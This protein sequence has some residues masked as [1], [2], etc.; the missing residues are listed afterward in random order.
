MA[1]ILVKQ[2]RARGKD[3][4][5]PTRA[6]PAA[7]EADEAAQQLRHH[8]GETERCSLCARVPKRAVVFKAGRIYCSIECAEAVAGLYL[9]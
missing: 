6:R 4:P 3:P 8:G 7:Q 2:D 9:G 1:A 5:L